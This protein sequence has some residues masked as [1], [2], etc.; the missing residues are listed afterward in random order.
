M[1]RPKHDNPT[2]A[3]L[4][5]LHALWEHGPMTV[6]Q[7]MEQLESRQDSRQKERQDR[8][9]TTVM[10]LMNVM[11][12]KGLLNR[13][14]D[15]RAFIYEATAVR[16]STLGSMLGDLLNRAFSGS[17]SLLVSQLLDQASPDSEELA[18]IRKAIKSY[19]READREGKREKEGE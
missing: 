1:A 3:E 9:Y 11:F 6:R 17:A 14:P 5:V 18:Q 7:V 10:S 16:E 4:E 8:A 2:P 15:G 12:E 19:Q 13:K